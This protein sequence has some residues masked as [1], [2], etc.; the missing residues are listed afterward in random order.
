[1]QY[2][3][4]EEEYKRGAQLVESWVEHN[5]LLENVYDIQENLNKQGWF[6]VISNEDDNSELFKITVFGKNL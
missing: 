1:M 4:T 2:I 5:L 6:T 3:L